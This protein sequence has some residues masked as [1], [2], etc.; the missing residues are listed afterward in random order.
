MRPRTGFQRLCDG[1]PALGVVVIGRSPNRVTLAY[2]NEYLFSAPTAAQLSA[3][4]ITRTQYDSIRDELVR[5][6]VNSVHTRDGQVRIVVHE[7]G[8]VPSG[9]STELVCGAPPSPLVSG[10][11][12]RGHSCTALEPG[13][14]LCDTWN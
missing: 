14:W 13:W 1:F 8:I 7:Q 5:I 4:G 9:L 6:G 12:D 10:S 2:G 11:P 3:A